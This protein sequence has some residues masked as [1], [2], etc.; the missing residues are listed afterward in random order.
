MS[1][2]GL[3]ADRVLCM[4]TLCAPLADHVFVRIGLKPNG[5]PLRLMWALQ[6]LPALAR[7]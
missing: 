7:L 6:A 1:L 4:A 5:M 3:L 2:G